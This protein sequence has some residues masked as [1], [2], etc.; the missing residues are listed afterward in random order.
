MKTLK[1]IMIALV[2]LVATTANVKAQS[3]SLR[4]VKNVKMINKA[5]AAGADTIS[6]TPREF[7][8]VVYHLLADSCYYKIATSANAFRGDRMTFMVK[9]STG[10][11]YALFI[12][13]SGF[14]TEG[15]DSIVNLS[16]AKRASIQFMFD[17]FKWVQTSIIEQ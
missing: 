15:A 14:E 12:P 2:C 11:G 16:S 1:V 10:G 9:D 5:D 4:T 13:A 17:G 6:I 8:T 7:E 3:A